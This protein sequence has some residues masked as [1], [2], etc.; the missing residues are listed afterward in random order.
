MDRETAN[1]LADEL[2]S[3]ESAGNKTARVSIDRTQAG[4]IGMAHFCMPV[5]L[6]AGF[7]WVAIASGASGFLAILIGAGIGLAL[8]HLILKRQRS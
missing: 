3:K 4:P 7:T 5:I 6:A 1:R 2:I 8:A